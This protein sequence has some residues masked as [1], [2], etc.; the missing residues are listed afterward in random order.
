MTAIGEGNLELA[1]ALAYAPW[2]SRISNETR[3][4]GAD[5]YA[6]NNTPKDYDRL[7]TSSPFTRNR[8]PSLNKPGKC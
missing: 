3:Q 5:L 8:M 6:Q 7:Q 1:R 2:K 4:R